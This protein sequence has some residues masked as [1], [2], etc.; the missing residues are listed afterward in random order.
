VLAPW[1]GNPSDSERERI[2]AVV[3]AFNKERVGNAHGVVE[4]DPILSNRATP[5]AAEPA[6]AERMRDRRWSVA[7]DRW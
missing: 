3:E 7:A 5:P 4:L 6:R 1:S 2:I